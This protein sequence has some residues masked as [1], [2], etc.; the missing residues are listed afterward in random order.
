MEFVIDAKFV[1]IIGILSLAI[2]TDQE[3]QR[4]PHTTGNL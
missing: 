2:I 3:F 4:S 1:V